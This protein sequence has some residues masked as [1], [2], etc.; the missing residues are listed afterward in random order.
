[1]RHGGSVLL[2]HVVC[3]SLSLPGPVPSAALSAEDRARGGGLE[4]R[5]N[6]VAE[7]ALDRLLLA[8]MSVAV[9]RGDRLELAKGYGFADLQ[10]RI[11]ARANTIYRTGSVGKQFTAAT[12]LRLAEE[13]KLSL[14][15]PVGKHLPNL[16][17]RLHRITVRQLLSHTAGL[18]EIN[19]DARFA[20]SQGVGMTFEEVLRLAARQPLEF[21]PG[22]GFSYSNSGYILAGG[23]IEAVTGRPAAGYM[24]DE[25]LRPLGLRDTSDCFRRHTGRWA[26]GYDPQQP[27]GWGRIVR[28]GRFP[29]LSAPQPINLRAISAAGAFCST[30]VDLIGWT[31]MLHHGDYLSAQSLREL[32]E[33]AVLPGGSRAPYGLGTQLRQFGEHRA[34]GHTG[35]I[36]GFNAVVAYFPDS[37]LAVAMMVNSLLPEKD[38]ILLW[39]RVLGAVFDEVPA[40]WKEPGYDGAPKRGG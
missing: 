2:F 3:L 28:L 40:E 18:R 14:E 30:P 24:T 34:L 29:V 11:R 19:A 6:A 20:R 13:G 35:I 4:G 17:R 8:G 37:D 31:S 23:I 5:V 26:R 21:E 36:S 1:M 16:P 10:K 27:G 12:I 39:E 38:G 7:Q 22:T 32:G 25:T 33:P 9:M 15:D